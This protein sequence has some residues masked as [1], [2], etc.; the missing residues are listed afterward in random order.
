ML[1]REWT[2][3][4]RPNSPARRLRQSVRFMFHPVTLECMSPCSIVRRHA[5]TARTWAAPRSALATPRVPRLRIGGATA[6]FA[7]GA[8]PLVVKTLGRWWSDG[9]PLSA[10]VRPP[11]GSRGGEGRCDDAPLARR[12]SAWRRGWAGRTGG[13]GRRTWR[14]RGRSTASPPSRRRGAAT[15]GSARRRRRGRRASRGL[16]VRHLACEV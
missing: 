12:W 15:R 3:G 1:H 16:N 6:L 8:S 14:G 9:T 2:S 13:S 11:H 5:S 4:M 7:A 10:R